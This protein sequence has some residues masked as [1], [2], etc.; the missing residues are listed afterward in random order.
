VEDR[1]TKDEP[2]EDRLAEDRLILEKAYTTVHQGL[3][4]LNRG[5]A[6]LNREV[7]EM[8]TV[9]LQ[10]L[11]TTVAVVFFLIANIGLDYYFWSHTQS[12][13]QVIQTPVNPKYDA[14]LRRVEAKLSRL[15]DRE[16]KLENKLDRGLVAIQQSLDHV[17]VH[18]HV[19]D[20]CLDCN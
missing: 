10:L 20:H 11:A 7:K 14:D 1:P 13:P 16:S 12:A 19:K 17:T 8:G 18:V 5:L 9:V 6:H 3:G 15:Q 2:V 4:H